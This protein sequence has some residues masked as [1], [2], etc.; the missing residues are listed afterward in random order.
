M[1]V[2]HE[3]CVLAIGPARRDLPLLSYK[4][5]SSSAFS[6]FT[7]SEASLE[8]RARGN[9]LGGEENCCFL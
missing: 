5:I 6:A 2:F 9:E 7:D 3:V 8:D 4:G 1:S